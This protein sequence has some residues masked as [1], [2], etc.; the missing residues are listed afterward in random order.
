[1]AWQGSIEM[2][3][4][5][6]AH[7]LLLALVLAAC[8][9]PKGA[10]PPPSA[11]EA[12]QPALAA[13]AA[14]PEAGDPFPLLGET[15]PAASAATF[16]FSR[17]RVAGRS[18]TTETGG[19]RFSWSGTALS[20]RFRGSQFQIELEDSGRNWFGVT[21]DGV[22]VS[23]KLS[24]YSGRRCYLVANHL[25]AG[26]H[27]LTITRL[28]EAM[29]G[30]SALLGANAGAAGEIFA[31]DAKPTRRLEVIGDSISAAYG[32][33]G[34]N[35]YCHF[36]PETENQALSYAA[37]LAR[38]FNAEL[39]T[40]AWSGKGIFSNRG[41][42]SDTIPMPVLW[43]RTLPL[44]DDSHW[45]FS[46]WAPDAVVIDLGTNDFAA[47][48]PD[49]GPFAEAYRVFLFRVRGLY[50]KAALFCALS[51][52]LSDQWP[53]GAHSRSLARA[54]I[55]TAIDALKRQGD[56]RVFYAEHQLTSD[57]EGWG[58]D[59]HPSRATQAR[60]ADELAAPLAK[61]LGW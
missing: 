35:R 51:P 27:R 59:W 2:L 10:P 50:P 11:L 24:A 37:V 53:P 26:E 61:N 20:F 57:A 56:D 15:C 22:D 43:E 18:E 44:H 23:Q 28:T 39:S 47:E 12:A 31:P 14:Q 42:T 38:R 36:S 34:E 19:V 58:C 5:R 40:V 21:L 7:G 60:M 48:N 17:V 29:L 49:K 45:D 52:L 3:G 4:S 16:D 25:A 54:G 33:E 13:S 8:I 30:D 1:M 46:T 9:V 6:L 55:Q 32:V 41:S